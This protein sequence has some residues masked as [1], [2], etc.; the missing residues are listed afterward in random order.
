MTK[1]QV[2]QAQRILKKIEEYQDLQSEIMEKYTNLD[3]DSKPDNIFDFMVFLIKKGYKSMLFD[4][5]INIRHK[6]EEDI[7]ELEK[8]LKEL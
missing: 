3:K 7:A 6:I 4:T 5:L 2:F 1:D 8:E